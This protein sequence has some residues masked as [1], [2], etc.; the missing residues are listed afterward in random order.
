MRLAWLSP[1]NFSQ[2]PTGVSA[3]LSSSRPL[4]S[5][6]LLQGL[7]DTQCQLE[8]DLQNGRR[9][10][11]RISQHYECIT[12]LRLEIANQKKS[13]DVLI[14]HAHMRLGYVLICYLFVYSFSY[15][16]NFDIL[17]SIN[18]RF[19]PST[20]RFFCLFIAVMCRRRWTN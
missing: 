17:E 14:K 7:V 8:L 3:D 6:Q 1:D 18:A 10:A 13:L 2:L 9:Y 20:Q 4:L 12:I 5:S 11:D 19:S 16:F 15:L